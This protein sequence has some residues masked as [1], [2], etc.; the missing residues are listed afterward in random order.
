[1]S[2]ADPVVQVLKRY[3]WGLIALV[4][5]AASVAMTA[6]VTREQYEEP[7]ATVRV[8][9]ITDRAEVASL[10]LPEFKFKE[11]SGKITF[12]FLMEGRT[13]SPVFVAISDNADDSSCGGGYTKPEYVNSN[14]FRENHTNLFR[15][16]PIDLSPTIA[17]FHCSIDEKYS[18]KSFTERQITVETNGWAY[19][20]DKSYLPEGYAGEFRDVQISMSELAA[21]DSFRLSGGEITWIAVPDEAR[22]LR[23]LRLGGSKLIVAWK[24]AD[25][26]AIRD[27]IL[28]LVGALLGFAAG[29]VL[30][31]VRPYI[32]RPDIAQP[33]R[34]HQPGGDFGLDL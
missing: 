18:H 13:T 19:R 15:V 28:L 8:L 6:Y 2:S 22:M 16:S 34:V 3:G 32:G 11:D 20:V 12:T 17:S 4:L 7:K 9:V 26:T 23:P 27:A 31:W 1:M 33:S 14:L 25:L 10:A 5:V 29:C 30:E 21:K 24:D